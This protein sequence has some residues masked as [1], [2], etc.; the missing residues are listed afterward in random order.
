[1]NSI[2]MPRT[3]FSR[4]QN[5]ICRRFRQNTK[6]ASGFMSKVVIG[7]EKVKI[8]S[9][10]WVSE[11]DWPDW[12]VFWQDR[13]LSWSDLWLFRLT[14]ASSEFWSRRNVVSGHLQTTR[15]LLSLLSHPSP[16]GCH[17]TRSTLWF[18]KRLT[19]VRAECVCVA[20]VPVMIGFLSLFYF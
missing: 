5:W 1:M 4:C 9:R 12:P 8:R 13:R 3:F 20:D 19:E 15:L 17:E 18:I 11:G 6:G 10:P 14:I 2:I 7:N 16:L